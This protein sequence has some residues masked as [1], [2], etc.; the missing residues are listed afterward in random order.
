V[1]IRILRFRRKNRSASELRANIKRQVQ[2][3]QICPFALFA[4]LI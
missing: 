4:K 3:R 1:V 2:I